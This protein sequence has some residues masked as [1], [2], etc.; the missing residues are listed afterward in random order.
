[1]NT[2]KEIFIGHKNSVTRGDAQ[3]SL[4]GLDLS[5]LS[6]GNVKIFAT[7]TD[8]IGYSSHCS[9]VFFF[10]IEGVF[11]YGLDNIASCA[12]NTDCT[13][14]H[15]QAVCR[16]NTCTLLLEVQPLTLRG[17]KPEAR[18]LVYAIRRPHRSA[19][20]KCITTLAV[21]EAPQSL[22]SM[23]TIPLLLMS[24]CILTAVV[25]LHLISSVQ[26]AEKLATWRGLIIYPKVKTLFITSILK[27]DTHQVVLQLKQTIKVFGET[28]LLQEY[29][30]NNFSITATQSSTHGSQTADMAIDIYPA[31]VDHV[32]G[33]SG[34]TSNAHTGVDDESPWWQISF[35]DEIPITYLNIYSRLGNGYTRLQIQRSKYFRHKL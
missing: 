2:A 14:G 22:R 23:Q 19:E 13:Q 18:H 7:V 20:L 28:D 21:G 3:I 35:E 15:P 24:I 32:P 29:H 8:Q 5:K 6:S 33:G 17:A 31:H 25:L 9:S 34:V 10:Y 4:D 27:M 12:V 26:Q 30:N 11:T 1:M 16:A